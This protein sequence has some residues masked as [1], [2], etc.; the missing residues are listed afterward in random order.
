MTR[1]HTR[2]N[3]SVSAYPVQTDLQ[4]E[5][6]SGFA[7]T[8]ATHYVSGCDQMRLVVGRAFSL[9]VCQTC[10]DHYQSPNHNPDMEPDEL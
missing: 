1:T 8:P 7:R 2:C 3:S 10:L 9:F 4:C 5:L 6:C